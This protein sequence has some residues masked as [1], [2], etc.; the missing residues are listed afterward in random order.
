MARIVEQEFIEITN[1]ISQVE[2]DQHDLWIMTGKQQLFRRPLDQKR[3]APVL[4]DDSVTSF[5]LNSDY[6]VYV[7]DETSVVVFDK[8]DSNASFARTFK[9]NSEVHQICFVNELIAI[10]SNE[11][12]E[13]WDFMKDD[14]R[15]LYTKRAVAMDMC[16]FGAEPHL[17]VSKWDLLSI[18]V[19]TGEEEV[20]DS[21]EYDVEYPFYQL[22]N[23]HGKYLA[24]N[25]SA[26][27]IVD[28]DLVVIAESN[29]I[30]AVESIFIDD[31]L[32][33]VREGG[34]QRDSENI[35]FNEIASID[36]CFPFRV[37][38]ASNSSALASDPTSQVFAISRGNK[39]TLYKL[40]D[41][42]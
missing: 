28:Q 4:V 14:R 36:E 17:L 11:G 18:N 26:L 22:T 27:Q 6:A 12:I 35:E 37:G 16:F 13:I 5:K 39:V 10:A 23:Y 34:V 21:R 7:K 24:I 8:T 31:R 40:A 3:T 33:I 20:L 2:L 30:R 9:S 42:K 1:C 32:L 19:Q 38:I 25:S 41:E 29:K 15:W